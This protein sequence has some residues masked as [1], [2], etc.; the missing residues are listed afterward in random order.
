MREITIESDCIIIE[1]EEGISCV[2][3]LLLLA[4]CKY[5]VLKE[6]KVNPIKSSGLEKG[7]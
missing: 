1:E 3:T 6:R 5:N 7:K 4:T 2:Y